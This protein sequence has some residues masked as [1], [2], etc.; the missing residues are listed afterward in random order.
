[1]STVN[2]NLDNLSSLLTFPHLWL[3]IQ[4]RVLSLFESDSKPFWSFTINCAI[5]KSLAENI[6]QNILSFFAFISLQ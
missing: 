4:F 5:I 2:L 6:F 3:R 1:M